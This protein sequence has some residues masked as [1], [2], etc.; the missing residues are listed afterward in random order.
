MTV[1]NTLNWIS[2]TY[3]KLDDSYR[4]TLRSRKR[5]NI[6]SARTGRGHLDSNWVDVG[7]DRDRRDW[8]VRLQLKEDNP[9]DVQVQQA[10]EES[11]LTVDQPPIFSCAGFFSSSM[12]GA[13]VAPACKLDISMS[14]DIW[15]MALE[16]PRKH[17]SVTPETQ[18]LSVS[19]QES[20][21]VVSLRGGE[22]L[23]CHLIAAG[24][25]FRSVRLEMERATF[26]SK[27]VEK[28][29]QL[30]TGST[31]ARWTPCRQ[32]FGGV[33]W[34]TASSMVRWQFASLLECLGAEVK[35][36]RLSS[37]FS[38]GRL[39]WGGLHR[40]FVISDGPALGYKLRLV[41]DRSLRPD[42]NNQSRIVVS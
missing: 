40:G 16:P 37:F 31:E 24:Q 27:S 2:A 41:M 20:S 22:E 4:V 36:D 25:G 29:G 38:R 8:V 26:R 14:P 5:L 19:R 35:E 28:I 12:E 17:L 13:I 33:I 23:V 3:A 9:V 30:E 34:V 32:D 42:V 1:L 21:A 18:S 39:R 11:V 15:I 7:P 10:D 6:R